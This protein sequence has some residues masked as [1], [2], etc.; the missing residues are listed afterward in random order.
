M[1]RASNDEKVIELFFKSSEQT[2]SK[3]DSKYGKIC[4]KLSYDDQDV[5]KRVNDAYLVA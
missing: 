3:L 4:G 5:E 1:R 2:I